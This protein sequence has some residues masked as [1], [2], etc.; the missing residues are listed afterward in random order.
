MESVQSSTSSSD[1]LASLNAQTRS[2]TNQLLSTTEEVQNRFLKL[3]VTQLKNQD[4]LNPLDNAAVTS[5]ISQINT[6]TGI[7]RLNTTL[8]TLLSTFNEGQAVQAAG[9]IGKNVLVGG[10][11]LALVNG[12]ANGGVNL[13]TPADNVTLTI[14]G[15]GDNV[16]QSERLGA[17]DAGSFA[18]TWDGMTAQGIPA[19]DGTYRFTVNAVRGSETVAAE[20]LQI[21]TVNALVREKGSYQLDLG[22]LGRVAFD[23]VQQIL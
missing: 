23:K 2:G 18:F 3:L 12:Q 21:G 22:G 1:I 14:F 11:G 7:E 10:S 20:A 6:V 15:A 8:E 19:P 5:Q 13:A 9:L 16:I 4:P 17:H